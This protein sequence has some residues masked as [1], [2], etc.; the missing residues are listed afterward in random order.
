MLLPFALTITGCSGLSKGSIFNK[1][2]MEANFGDQFK[3]TY[4]HKA[5]EKIDLDLGDGVTYYS[6]S[7]DLIFVKKSTNWGYFSI[8]ER[9]YIMPVSDYYE[10]SSQNLM[11]SNT[12]DGDA[13]IYFVHGYKTVSSVTTHYVYDMY[14]NEIFVGTGESGALANQSAEV[15]PHSKGENDPWIRIDLKVAGKIVKHVFYNADRSFKEALTPAEY[16]EKNP[17][18]AMGG[19]SL[20]PWGHPELIESKENQGNQDRYTIYNTKKD[21]FVS[22][23]AIPS[24]ATSLKIGDNYFYQIETE[25]PVREKKYDFFEYSGGKEHKYALETYKINILNGKESKIKTDFRFKSF[26][27][28]DPKADLVN[29]KGIR[30]YKYVKAVNQIGKDK[31]LTPPRNIILN[32][33]LK[34]VA[35]VSAINLQNLVPCGD[36]YYKYGSVIYDAHLKEV[37]YCQQLFNDRIAMLDT[38]MGVVDKT[39]KFIIQPIYEYVEKIKGASVYLAETNKS[40]TLFKV[41]DKGAVEE[42]KKFEFEKYSVEQLGLGYLRLT[43]NESGDELALNLTTGETTTLVKAEE[44]YYGSQ[45]ESIE[46]KGNTYALGG[47][48]YSKDGVPKFVIGS[49]TKITQS[50]KDVK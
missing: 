20:A 22:S 25:V 17:Y 6:R 35:D 50:Y 38:Y 10:S 45:M 8:S 49:E 21:K 1:K 30:E 13:R 15:L 32:D 26:I 36:D 42:L 34:E 39:G 29:Q 16:Y 19:T 7:G 12:G 9:K 37:G 14:G 18:L 23:F 43:D 31:L 48:I 44:G 3:V 47:R 4:E 27:L 33:K 5:P 11:I 2:F 28:N 46:R 24:A 40:C 41:T